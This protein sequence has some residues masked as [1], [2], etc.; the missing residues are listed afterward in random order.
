MYEIETVRAKTDKDKLQ[1]L[2]KR[3]RHKG[4]NGW[5]C[6]NFQMVQL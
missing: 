6:R 4:L 3:Q 1:K 2:S 5:K